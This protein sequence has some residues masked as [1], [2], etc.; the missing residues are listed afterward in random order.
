MNDANILEIEHLTK[1]FRGVMGLEDVALAVRVGEIHGLLGEN[2][3]GKTTLM[4]L[5]GGLYKV[6]S[7][8]G[9][10]RM[11]GK[12]AALRS[13]RDSLEQ[14]IA[15]VPSRPAVFSG[16][17]VA[18]NIVLG[19]WQVERKFMVS[20][21]AARREAAETLQRLGVTLDLE[22]KVGKLPAGQKRMVVL[23][24]ALSSNPRLLVLDE[25]SVF[26]SGPAEI[27]SLMRLLRQLAGQGISSLYLTRAPL[28]AA[29]IADRITV[30]RDGHTT[31]TVERESFDPATLALAMMSEHPERQPGADDAQEEGGLFGSLR[32]L[33]SFGSRD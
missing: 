29:Q 17:S 26:A 24:R 11:A 19:R 32:N 5:L 14:G 10:I 31:M 12:P 23:A 28:E 4:K 21:D 2:G 1:P 25:P 22:A 6:D 30:L 13:P 18:E 9:E 27:S 3:A 20:A 16:L 15:V 33:F 7:Y 8:Q